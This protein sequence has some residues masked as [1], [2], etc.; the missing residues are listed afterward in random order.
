MSTNN[1]TRTVATNVAML[2]G[3]LGVTQ[4]EL[5]KISG[6][7]EADVSKL[8]RASKPDGDADYNFATATISKLAAALNTTVDALTGHPT[9]LLGTI[10]AGPNDS[11]IAYDE[12]EIV[13]F[14][15]PIPKDGYALR[16]CG[17]SCSRWGICH[18]DVIAIRPQ[19][20]PQEG[21]FCVL[22]SSGGSHTL[23]AYSRGKWWQF[24][25]TD[26]EPVEYEFDAAT[27]MFGVV[28]GG[29]YGNRSF[30]AAGRS[31]MKNPRKKGK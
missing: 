8:L 16:V 27:N 1:V 26:A 25:P 7:S 12:P 28:I 4:R 6:M 14:D 24:R 9:L 15:F 11:P 3:R 10:A 17:H 2:I 5:G 21:V 19:I 29:K 23:K 31:P 18:D 20:E 22:R 13:T 30:A